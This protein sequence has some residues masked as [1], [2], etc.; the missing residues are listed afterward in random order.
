[1]KKYFTI[2]LT[3]ILVSALI[4]CGSFTEKD[5]EFA[6]EKL[7]EKFIS[8]GFAEE[9]MQT[10]DGRYMEWQTEEMKEA[11]IEG[12]ECFAMELRFSGDEGING[13][14]A[15]R[16]VG[17]YAVSKNGTA[18]YQYNMADDIWEKME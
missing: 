10:E 11:E 8:I 5:A 15:S 4:G 2:I 1:M 12:T 18:F 3:F 16:L 9:G 14:M 6:S 17:I 7:T 13:E